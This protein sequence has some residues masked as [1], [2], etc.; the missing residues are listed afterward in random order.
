MI[1]VSTFWTNLFSFGKA[2]AIT[3]FPFIFLKYPEFK[4]NLI[5]INH[6]KIHIRQALELGVVI[7]YLWY[8]IEFMVHYIRYHDFYRAYHAISFER[9]AYANESDMDYLGKRRMWGFWRY[10]R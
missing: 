8:V 3:I 2:N 7:F 5:L 4:G 10:H 1:I 9:E 6:E